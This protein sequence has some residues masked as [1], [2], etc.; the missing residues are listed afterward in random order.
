MYEQLALYI[1]GE[2]LSGDG[3]HSQD[4]TNQAVANVAANEKSQGRILGFFSSCRRRER[5]LPA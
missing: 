4:V 3:R 2:F 1:D 5:R